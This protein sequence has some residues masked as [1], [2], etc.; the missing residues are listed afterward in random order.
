MRLGVTSHRPI[1]FLRNVYWAGSALGLAGTLVYPSPIPVQLLAGAMTLYTLTDRIGLLDFS[2]IT[3]PEDRREQLLTLLHSQLKTVTLLG[4]DVMIGLPTIRY[5]DQG[6]LGL[7]WSS[8]GVKKWPWQSSFSLD[9]NYSAEGFAKQG[10]VAA[11]GVYVSPSNY[12]FKRIT[13][14]QTQ[15]TRLTFKVAI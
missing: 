2:L 8:L 3:K 12:Y 9:V 15:P 1:S 4:N 11:E 14:H 7:L 13:V 10:Y 5:A 6:F